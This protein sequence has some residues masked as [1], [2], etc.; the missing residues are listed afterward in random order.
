MAANNKLHSL[1]DLTGN[2][3]RVNDSAGPAALLPKT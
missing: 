2:C 3:V 1:A